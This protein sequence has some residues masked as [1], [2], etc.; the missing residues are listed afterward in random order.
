MLHATFSLAEQARRTAKHG[1]IVLLLAAAMLLLGCLSSARIACSAEEVPDTISML[2]LGD[3]GHHRPA[4]RAAELIPAMRARG[5]DITYTEDVNQLSK[6]TLAQFDGLIVYANIDQITPEQEG[7]L[8]EFVAD[9]KGFVPLHC[10]SFCFRNS[11]KYVQLVGA[12]FQR[13]GTG[14]FGTQIAAPNHP[15]MR[16][17]S[18]FESW[19]E[20]YVHHLHNDHD[21]TVLEYRVDADGREPWTWVRTHGQGRVFYTAWGHD[22]RTFGHAGFQNLIER[23]IRWAVGADPSK[24]P[25]YRDP[26][27][28]PVPP[29]TAL[30]TDVKPF[31]FV[32]ADVPYYPPSD[33]WGV[34]GKP[35]TKMQQ[36]LPP[37]EAIKHIV[38]PQGFEVRLFA[39]DPEITKPI[40][41][42]WDARGRLW[43]GETIDYPNQLKP[44]GEGRD[45]IKICEDTDADGRADK[46]TVFAEGLSIPTSIAFSHGGVI[47]QDGIQTLFL[48]D[49]TGDDR[50]DQRRVLFSGWNM[51]DTHGGVSNFRYGLDN[52]IWA[53][54]GYN[55][56]QP[57]HDDQR[58]Q[59]FRM[60]FFRF[61]PDGSEI[62]FVRSTD[63]NTWGLGISEEGL[64]FG[65]TANR[66]PSVYMPI[67]NRYYERVRGWSAT[68]LGTIADTHLFQPITRN[69]RQVDQHGGYTA[70]AGH[71]LYTARTYPREYWNRTAFVCGP[72]GHLV[73]TFVLQA[74]GADFHSRNRFNLFASDDEWSAPIMAEVGPDG[75]VWVLDWYNYIV[76]HNPTPAGFKTGRGNA[77]E[78]DLRDK[79]HGRIYRVVYVG[80]NVDQKNVDRISPADLGTAST[81]ALVATLKHPTMLWRQHAQRL[82]VERG[83][84]EVVPALIELVR[85]QTVDEIGL[86]VGAIHAL[87]TLDGLGALSGPQASSAAVAAVVSS[88]AHASAGVR[89]NAA[90]VLPRN[91]MSLPLLA[92]GKLLT[93]PD[94]QVRQAALL[95]LSEIPPQARED[96]VGRSL[97]E[98]LSALAPADRWLSDGVTTAAAT[99][100]DAFLRAAARTK[101]L[102]A[103]VLGTLAIVAEH[104]ARSGKVESMSSLLEAL[105]TSSPATA[106]AIIQ[107][108]V[109]GTPTNASLAL[110]DR[111]EA[112]IVAV[113]NTL[114]A[115]TKGQLVRLATVWG[116]RKLA[117]Y[118]EQIVMSLVASVGN[119]KSEDAVRIDAARQLVDF[120]RADGQAAA[121]L[122]ELV[123]PRTSPAVAAGIIDALAASEAGETPSILVARFGSL[124]PSGRRAAIRVL[125]GRP[126]A[127]AAL[128]DAMSVG[129]I[130]LADLSLDQQ[131][132]LAAHPNGQLA[133]RA[134]KLLSS[135]GGL[136]NPDRQKVLVELLPLASQTADAAAGKLVFTKQCAKCHM[137]NGEGQKI[138]PDLTGMA[139]HPKHE[140][141][142]HIIDPS[143]SV[144]GNFRVY[145]VITLDGRVLNGLLASETK[146]SIELFDAEGKQ[147]VV[148]REDIDE[149]I[150]SAKSLMP[151]GFEK[152]VSR[153]DIANLL[154]FLTQR[155][156][157]IPIPL[158]KA[159]TIVSTRGMFF[160]KE[161]GAE[162]LIFADWSPKT[163]AG[164]PF[165]L[166]DPRGDRVPNVIMLYGPRGNFP[167][168]MPKT[169]TLPCNA[170]AKAIHLLSG[171]SGWGFPA[172][173]EKSVSMIVRLHFADGSTEDHPLRNAVHFADYIRHVDVPESK[174]AF[175][176]R[177]QQIRYLSVV[178]NKS[179]VIT[180]IELV[181]GPDDTAPVVMA[182]TVE[183]P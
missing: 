58:A 119:E 16:G 163:F 155:G 120:R 53:M 183:S 177:G 12:Q 132:A 65:S 141:L 91:E 178:P 129:K 144:E 110:S 123:T 165:Q 114:P 97:V 99:H 167:P 84:R 64:V 44:P 115:S 88:C 100:S 86:N 72:T 98:T 23:G 62:E 40:C 92:D 151:E 117:T 156:K 73:G 164:V 140:L 173:S 67:A 79:R 95:A 131:Q 145:S 101:T 52:W 8:L 25:A 38:T 106:A 121:T 139:V 10:A 153:E 182:V 159:A 170:P 149:L 22:Q 69:V 46:F 66:N 42:A 96:Q 34:M 29:M 169:V 133:T 71:A 54:Q 21:R 60:G 18:S 109:R 181:K 3:Q 76:Q 102:P 1:R 124:T 11:E 116:S 103:P 93:D 19:D 148:L 61:R 31:E 176:L 89:R 105:A 118:A 138:G 112:N 68:Q 180:S 172:T 78:T 57:T 27:S 127:T 80:D 47:V 9:G 20:T 125:L 35:I 74:D 39:S 147:H 2:F 6:T 24:V 55:Q 43:V 113:L 157:F 122:L 154:E 30:R 50:A 104:H 150:A 13:H 36:P 87:W 33:R 128:L 75:N 152:Q 17:Y 158:G 56:S 94:R 130:P 146:T 174:L 83:E 107:G 179:D 4:D 82:L 81:T 90:L 28:F 63:N 45:R 49:T 51:R 41:M 142:T 168:R 37:D 162:R 15:V 136:P 111:D 126:T 161:A 77:Y 175:Q 7:A 48:K 135:G 160:D 171:V 166:I 59:G 108:L 26:A 137:H 14:V 32:E 70:G 143:R 134:R 85:D 5:I